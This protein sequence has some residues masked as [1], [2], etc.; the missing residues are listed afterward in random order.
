MN[1][2]QLRYA[3][4]IKRPI[5]SRVLPEAAKL[6]PRNAR[7]MCNTVETGTDQHIDRFL[8]RFLTEHLSIRRFLSVLFGLT[9]GARAGF[10]AE[11]R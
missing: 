11:V 8:L 3:T 6:P 10:Q 1:F 7:V 9:S 5:R 2:H 4:E